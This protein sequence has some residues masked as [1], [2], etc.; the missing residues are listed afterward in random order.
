MAKKSRTGLQSKISHIFSGVPIPKKGRSRAGDRGVK[1]KSDEYEILQKPAEQP[2]TPQIQEPESQIEQPLV[3]EP[4]VERMLV[5]Q[6]PIQE[7]AVKEK[8]V[9]QA[10]VSDYTDEESTVEQ[11]PEAGEAATTEWLVEQPSAELGS[12]LDI[13]ERGIPVEK[14]PEMPFSTDTG[15]GKAESRVLEIPHKVSKLPKVK[16][17]ISRSSVQQKRQRMM[18]VLVIVLSIVLVFLLFK[19]FSLISRDTDQPVIDEPTAANLA[20]GADIE[21]V[22]I[23]WPVPPDY[24]AELHDPMELDAVAQVQPQ[25]F[26]PVVKGITTSN[27]GQPLAVI[28]TELVREGEEIFGITVIKINRS[29]VVFEKDG[30]RWSQE[31]QGEQ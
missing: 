16:R 13:P 12:K 30:E 23:D 4:E 10:S 1:P 19:P 28:G 25:T 15:A 31:V 5:E 20:L 17:R 22:T 26:K 7:P 24:P 3:Q 6:P 11:R 21:V 18:L 27:E 8:Q 14:L 9:E 29:D 2:E